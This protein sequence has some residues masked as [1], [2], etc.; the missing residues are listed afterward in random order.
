MLAQRRKR[1]EQVAR[2]EEQVAVEQ[3]HTSCESSDASLVV[4]HILRELRWASCSSTHL[5][6]AQMV[7]L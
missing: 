6:R 4:A 5:A 1:E 7:Q 2:V 3:Q